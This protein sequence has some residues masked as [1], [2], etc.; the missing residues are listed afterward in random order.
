MKNIVVAGIGYVGLANAVALAQKNHVVVVD[1]QQTRVNMINSGKSPIAD[2]EIEDFLGKGKIHLSATVS[3]E[4]ALKDAKVVFIATPTDYDMEKNYF[5][6]SSVENVIQQVLR[7][8]PDAIMVIKSTIP[9]GFTRRMRALYS[10]A[11][12]I[13]SPEFLREGRA[14]YDCLY[15]SRIIVGDSSEDG[16]IIGNL[17][18]ESAHKEDVQVLYMGA[19][20]AEAVKL[21]SNTYLAMR[22]AYFNELDTYAFAHHLDSRSIINGMSADPRIGD[23]YNN[24]SFGYGGY[25]LPK[26]T[27]QLLANYGDIPQQLMTAIVASNATRKNVIVQEILA[28]NPKTIG[29]YRLTMKSHS[30]N[31]RSAAIFD[32][33][34]GLDDHGIH[35]QI[36]E[37]AVTVDTYDKWA[38]VK[39]IDLFKKSS[40]VIVA[41]RMEDQIFDVRNKVYTKDIYSRD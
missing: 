41:N 29:I 24:P 22:I 13:F 31:F 39:D 33:I 6:C 7:Y 17:L 27:K 19:D 9:L 12:I 20:E 37:P 40:D 34:Q 2:K 25:C 16:V 3:Y 4:N 15:P 35:I 32:I 14:L 18:K 1:I 38:V 5:D 8:A 36:Y 26:D 23:Y 11:H 10:Q 28:M 21:F 30:D